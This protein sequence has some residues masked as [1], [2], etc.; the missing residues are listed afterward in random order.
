MGVE[1]FRNGDILVRSVQGFGSDTC[2]V[3]FD[4]YSDWHTLDRPGFGENF[5]KGSSIDA[6]HFI[7]RNNDWYQYGELPEIA[8]S[9]SDITKSS[10]HRV[11]TYGSSMGGYAAIRFGRI[12]GAEAA[13]AISPQFSI[14][15]MTV[16]F[17]NRWSCDAA[18]IDFTLERSLSTE[19]VATSYVLYDPHDP[20]RYHVD[21]FRGRTNVI[22][23]SIP[24]GGHPLTGY[25]VEAGLLKE[26]VLDIICA[27][28]DP[29]RLRCRAREAR[30]STPQ[31]F[32][33]LSLRSRQ[34]SARIALARRAAT[35]APDNL[36][37]LVHL[38][39]VLAQFGRFEEAQEAFSCAEA[40]TPNH[41]VLLYRVSELYEWR[42]DLD[43]AYATMETLV[44]RHPETNIYLPR[45]QYLDQLRRKL[46]RLESITRRATPPLDVGTCL[47]LRNEKAYDSTDREISQGAGRSRS[48]LRVI[49]SALR[50]FRSARCGTAPNSPASATAPKVPPIEILV[51]TTPSPPP[52]VHSWRRHVELM[53]RFPRRPVDLVL[54]GDSLV[55]YWPDALWKPW[56]VFNFG[57][58]ADKTQ[59]T[60]WRL[61]QVAP[62][63]IQARFVVVML[64]T[65]N[66]AADDTAR[67]IAAGVAAVVAAVARVAP[68]TRPHVIAMPPCG[69][70]YQFRDEVRRRANDLLAEA[71]SFDTINVDDAITCGFA[72]H[73]PNYLEDRI[74]FSDTGY[75]VLTDIVRRR[76]EGGP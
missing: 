62:A 52:F 66:L 36:G 61:Q 73:C 53:G 47:D 42:G 55:H 76:I 70:G 40:I 30:K 9:V 57:I 31:Y 37:Y 67:G 25:L 56:A 10:Y 3:T 5:F 63:S 17:E 27:R 43:L 21:L 72:E 74:H 32:Q 19:F 44:A 75:R 28:L 50:W 59:H 41:P 54:V 68:D 64:G 45:L 8:A 22:D 65:N 69:P 20:D 48:V 12:A 1:L 15:P 4:C 35:L 7:S 2:I 33:V 71:R 23:I 38:G 39:Y 6:I 24:Y 49:A 29:A 46:A 13:I 18:R 51:T 14:D 60:L 34:P 11:L 16:P 26:L 58:A